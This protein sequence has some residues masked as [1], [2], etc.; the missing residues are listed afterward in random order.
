MSSFPHAT[1]DFPREGSRKTIARGKKVYKMQQKRLG[2][3]GGGKGIPLKLLRKKKKGENSPSQGERS[4][5]KG[6]GSFGREQKFISRAGERGRTRA[7]KLS[8]RRK[9]HHQDVAGTGCKRRPRKI[10]HSGK[11]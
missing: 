6:G 7:F 2:K 1:S 5:E 9:K 8:E 11:R 3:G 10:S 4:S